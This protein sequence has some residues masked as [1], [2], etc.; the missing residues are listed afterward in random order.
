MAMSKK[1]WCITLYFGGKCD[2]IDIARRCT[3]TDAKKQFDELMQNISENHRIKVGNDEYA[4][5]LT[6]L[7][8]VYLREDEYV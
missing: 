1:H 3:Y 4:L 5:N 2:P 6:N 7:A 8:Y